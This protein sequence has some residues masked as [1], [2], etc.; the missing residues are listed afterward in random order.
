MI[1]NHLLPCLDPESEDEEDA[2]LTP[3]EIIQPTIAARDSGDIHTQLERDIQML[4]Q[5][6]VRYGQS[7]SDKIKAHTLLKSILLLYFGNISYRDK[8]DKQFHPWHEL[9][10]FSKLK[11]FP[12]AAALLHGSRVLIELSSDIS[13]ELIKWFVPDDTSWR[14]LATHGITEVAAQ[15][16]EGETDLSAQMPNKHLAE[17]KVNPVDEAMRVLAKNITNGITTLYNY[18]FS[19][20][21]SET[22]ASDSYEGH[23]GINIALG[24]AENENQHSKNKIQPNGEHGHLYF[25]YVKPKEERHGG[26][27]LGIEQSAPGKPDQYGGSH[28][29]DGA[30]KN[31]SASGGDF[32]CKAGALENLPIDNYYDSLWNF[33]SNQN[34]SVI[35]ESYN[36]ICILLDLLSLDPST[37]D[38]GINFIKEIVSSSGQG[39]K[40]SMDDL[41]N[42]YFVKTNLYKS[43]QQDFNAKLSIFNKKNKLSN[44]KLQADFNDRL[45]LH[46]QS[47][48]ERTKCLM[49]AMQRLT[50]ENKSLQQ[51]LAQYQLAENQREEHVAREDKVAVIKNLQALTSMFMKNVTNNMG[52]FAKNSKKA[53]IFTQLIN[54]LDGKNANELSENDLF[55]M[56][57]NFI[58][59]AIMNRYDKKGGQTHSGKA[60]LNLLNDPNYKPLKTLL[61]SQ[62]S[63]ID[64]LQ[65]QHLLSLFNA[66]EQPSLLTSARHRQSLYNAFGLTRNNKNILSAQLDLAMR[67][68]LYKP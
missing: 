25:H 4:S 17:K 3:F 44:K 57:K 58:G 14:Y 16:R 47:F 55:W 45:Q 18:F 63:Q 11:T 36:T 43:L 50:E 60:C 24:G 66:T 62:S 2:T 61:F 37:K 28:G 13:E 54:K 38:E 7:E 56:L 22:K 8:Q 33:I 5:A 29:L 21:G 53:A 9:K 12:I 39:S 15:Q 46:T 49:G 51:Q 48:T 6:I 34:F 31:V 35:Q 27:L 10:G 67:E 26:L 64:D 59:V 42:K 1:L 68:F 65:Y 52:R 30:P 41:C 23:Y 20:L 32:F 19:F 40:A